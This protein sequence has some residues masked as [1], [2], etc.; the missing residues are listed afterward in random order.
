MG[1]SIFALLARLPLDIVRVDV[2]AL[3]GRDDLVRAGQV[4]SAIVNT[5]AGFDVLTIA[6]GIANAE[7][8]AMA[9]E[10]GVAL[11]HGRYLPHDLTMDGVTELLDAA[12]RVPTA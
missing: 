8:L 3:A 7:M 4:L 9:D 2:P 12:D 6:G 10:A 5:T 1:H 11:V